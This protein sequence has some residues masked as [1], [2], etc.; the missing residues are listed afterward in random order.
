MSTIESSFAKIY[1]PLSDNSWK[2]SIAIQAT[3]MLSPGLNE[4]SW[5]KPLEQNFR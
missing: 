5:I 3:K 2:A 1:G 4:D